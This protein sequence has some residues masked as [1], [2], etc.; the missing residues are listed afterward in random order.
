MT[1]F[2]PIGPSIVVTYT[3]DSTDTSVTVNMGAVGCPN[4]LYAV[5]EDQAN[6]VAVNVSFDSNDTNAKVPDSGANGIGCIIA[7]YGYAMISIP[8]AANANTTFYVSA[9][10]HS[11]TGN[12]YIT[13]GVTFLN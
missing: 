1:P 3:D 6:I 5:N 7:P 8:Q 12:V 2:S 10:G 13:P 9:A 4:V 11:P